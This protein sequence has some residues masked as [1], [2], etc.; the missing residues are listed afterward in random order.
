MQIK[1]PYTRTDV[2][3]KLQFRT[4]TIVAFTLMLNIAGQS[5]LEAAAHDHNKHSTTDSATHTHSSKGHAPGYH[6]KFR[7]AKHW[8]KVFDDPERDKWQHPDKVV[9]ALNI[10]SKD[11]IADIGAGT[12]YFSF[13]IAKAQPA[14]KVYAADVEKDMLDF[15]EE[16]SKRQN[17][18]NVIPIEIK[19]TKPELPEK[20]TIVLIV[21]TFHH[22]DSRVQYFK[23]LK[24]SLKENGRIVIIDFTDKSPVGPP[25]DHRIDRSEVIAELK[26]AGFRLSKEHNFLPHQ[27]FLEFSL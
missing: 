14:A 15:L 21:D 9:E 19:T 11:V 22:I 7:D 3:M 18:K 16:E 17:C 24:A 2:Q 23:D 13:R 1:C 10:S 27:Y 25:K 20:S 8:V 5:H 4:L 6:R 26:E 12:G